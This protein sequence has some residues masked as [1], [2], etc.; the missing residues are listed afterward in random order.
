MTRLLKH[1][2]K[3]VPA[4]IQ[5]RWHDRTRASRKRAYKIVMCKGKN[6]ERRRTALYRELLGYQRRVRG[7]V[8][9]ALGTMGAELAVTT[10]P[11][12]MGLIGELKKM[13]DLAQRVY[14]QAY[15][16]VIL[17][18]HVAAGEKLVSIFETHT[19]I[20]CRG[21]KGSKTEFGHK[22]DI[23]T[24]RSGLITRYEVYA[25]NP[26][27]GDVLAR[28][29]EDHK[30]MFGRVPRRVTG[31][32]RYHSESNEQIAA[33]A[34][35]EEVALPKPGH[36]S[37]VRKS[38]Q[39]V[40]WFRHLMRWRAGVEGNLSTLLRSFGLKRCLWK[41]WRSFKAYIGLGVLTYNLRLL[42]G[43][44]AGA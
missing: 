38:L 18:E 1:L 31:D 36:L 9:V 22:F 17:G 33:D 8:E 34:G 4:T 21:K 19:D 25:G 39:K 5:F 30:R 29:L 44:L 10:D 27:D 3:E 13:L 16:R 43:H 42:A 40:P 32:R 6:I 28:S 11:I 41:G 20:I 2:R 37:E 26:C 24:G 14:D 12:V 35:V 7:Y 15:R 23:A